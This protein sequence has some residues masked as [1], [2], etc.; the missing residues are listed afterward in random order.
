MEQH[1]FLVEQR[2]ILGINLFS[3]LVMILT[4]PPPIDFQNALFSVTVFYT[5]LILALKIIQYQI[6]LPSD[7]HYPETI[8]MIGW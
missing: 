3:L 6:D 8:Y 5:V 7:P 4:K 2:D 1:L